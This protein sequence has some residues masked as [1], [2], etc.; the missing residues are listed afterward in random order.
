MHREWRELGR[1]ALESLATGL[2]VS[3]VL[4]LAVFIVSF[5]AH[6]AG[7]GDAGQGALLLGDGSGEKSQ[8]PL[9]LTDVHMGISGMAA[10]VQVRQ[11]FVN[12]SAGW[13]EGVYVFPLP[14]K[15]AV[16]HLT[17]HVGERVIEG[18][19]KERDGVMWGTLLPVS[20]R[21]ND[22][23]VDAVKTALPGNVPEGLPGFEQLPRTA[24]SAELSL[25]LGLLLLLAAAA[26][27]MMRGRARP[28]FANT[29]QEV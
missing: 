11:R 20:A 24:T 15:P 16:D 28:C 12:P 8:A 18:Q 27:G 14:D 3:L 5:E 25:L 6:A 21:A 23:D 17:M 10:R 2:F 4:A 13:S 9:L 29:L 22:A 19:I 7:T 26:I 1:L